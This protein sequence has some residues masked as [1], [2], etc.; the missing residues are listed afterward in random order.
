MAPPTTSTAVVLP[1]AG[2]I[3]PQ[4][5]P[6]DSSAALSFATSVT[7]QSLVQMNHGLPF[8]P[9]GIL[10]LD[11]NTPALTVEYATVSHPST[12][13]TELTFGFPFTGSIFLS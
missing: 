10:C 12:G 8:K 9:A 2:P 6:G 4:G 1:I 7:N 13:I 3:G 5:P 11:T